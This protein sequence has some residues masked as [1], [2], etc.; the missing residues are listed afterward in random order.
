MSLKSLR[1]K[2]PCYNYADICIRE[3]TNPSQVFLIL[4]GYKQSGNY[5]D[6]EFASLLPDHSI[7]ISPNG[8]FPQVKKTSTGY[9]LNYVWYFFDPVSQQ[10][11]IDYDLPATFLGQV[12]QS[13]DLGNL[14]LTIIGYSQG[15]YLSPFAA[16]KIPQTKRIIMINCRLRHDL[17]EGSIP[18][19]VDMIQG[20]EDDVVNAKSSQESH[21]IL[22]EDRKGRGNY[23]LLPGEGYHIS[24]GIKNCLKKIL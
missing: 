7:I 23:H 12:Y 1:L 10:F 5:I 2:V 9:Q 18:F 15:G 3:N 22:L 20:E 19:I 6:Q 17:L 16:K 4:H 11:F 14:P 21:K 24:V 8:F 13:L